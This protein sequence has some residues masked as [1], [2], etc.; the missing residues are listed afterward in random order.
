[1]ENKNN[2]DILKQV[3]AYSLNDLQDYKNESGNELYDTYEV[4]NDLNDIEDSNDYFKLFE[5]DIKKDN[6][7][8][9]KENILKNIVFLL[10]YFST[11]IAIFLV[12]LVTTNYSAYINIAK[13]YFYSDNIENKWNLLVQSIE[14]SKIIP[15]EKNEKIEAIKKVVKKKEIRA[16]ENEKNKIEKKNK[17]SIKKLVNEVDKKQAKLNIE[18]TPYSN[19][20]VIPRIWK[21]IP[22]L[23]VK[24][25]YVSWSK[26][27]EN[28]FMEELKNWVIRYPG[29]TKPWKDWN[30]FIFWH[31]SNFPWIKWD[32]NDVFSLL[33]N[34]TYWDEIYI[35]YWQKKYTYKIKEKKVIKPWNIEVLKRQKNIDEITLMTCW[36]VWTT[37]NRLIVI[38]E[39][40]KE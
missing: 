19:R 5:E 32:Y 17:Y 35:Y 40:V 15:K 16:I 4:N 13:S 29:S 27:L 6:K 39:I 2:K 3:E 38:W 25:Q 20:I 9:K 18:I 22:L 37:L 7:I 28:I 10:K 14:W 21:N 12:L 26:E 33:D 31:S 1:M 24:S 23:D 11:S 8:T 30:T 36:P 34:V